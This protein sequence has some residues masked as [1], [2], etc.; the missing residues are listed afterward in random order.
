MRGRGGRSSALAMK[1]KKFSYDRLFRDL[2]KA[3][4]DARR[5][6]R[7]RDYQLH[8]ESRLEQNLR[9]LCD[10]LYNRTYR[11]RPSACF[12]ISDPKYREVF[13]A[14]FRDRI[15]HHLYF[16]YLHEMLERTFIVDSYSCIRRRGT[17]FGIWRLEEHIRKASLNYTEKCYVLKLDIR[18]YFM[19]IKREKLLE[20]VLRRI[21][22]M[23]SHRIFR[24]HPQTWG[25]MLDMDFLRWLSEEIIML[26]PL[27]N[28]VIH[29]KPS[30]WDKLPREKSLF[31]APEGCGLP[32]GNLTSQLFSNVYLGELDDFMKRTLKCRH[33]GRYVDDFYVVSP[34][35]V[36]LR[37]LIPQVRDFLKNELELDLQE[38]KTVICDVKNG[39]EYLGHF[40]KNG[41]RRV[42]H[43]TWD[44]MKAKWKSWHEERDPVLLAAR[45]T[46]YRGM[47]F[48][49]FSIKVGNIKKNN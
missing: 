26:N 37:S 34:D 42:S 13:A 29:G 23:S 43:A 39:V 3:Y 45:I 14:D 28:C 25:D 49:F 15:V 18:G 41:R 24:H 22:N 6:K 46:S 11:A 21:E 12:I 30:D 1:G 9:E 33:Y 17:S 35:K 10:E 44:R 2:H 38:G 31:H 5:K 32:I 8:F 19:H 27:E 48:S 40:L 36:W 4:Y 16:N 47:I 20:I 7:N